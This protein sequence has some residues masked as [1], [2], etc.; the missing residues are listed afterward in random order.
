MKLFLPIL[1]ITLTTTFTT[2]AVYA[3]RIIHKPSGKCVHPKGR[4]SVKGYYNGDTVYNLKINTPLVLH[5]S[6]CEVADKR[7]D[8]EWFGNY[9]RHT[10]SGFCVHPKGGSSNPRNNT[11]LVLYNTCNKS[12][13]EFRQL[14]SGHIQHK[15]SGKCIHPRGGSPNPRDDTQLVLDS[16]CVGERIQF[17]INRLPPQKPPPPPRNFTNNKKLFLTLSGKCMHPQGRRDDTQEGTRLVVHSDRCGSPDADKLFFT[18][19]PNGS[20]RHEHSGKCIMPVS[21]GVGSVRNNTELM[22]VTDCNAQS[23]KFTH[24]PSGSLQHISNKC[25][26]PK[27]GSQNPRNDTKFVLYDTCD[28]YNIKFQ[29]K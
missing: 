1:I 18:M 8:F 21:R 2:T 7:L 5:A 14:P 9:I 17:S 16:L 19:N 13:I 22:L 4:P 11:Q 10:D 15:D 24:R 29:F 3:D 6:D 20:I 26:H 25:I 27:G 12:S 28:S 23:T